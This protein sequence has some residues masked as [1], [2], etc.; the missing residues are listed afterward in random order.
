MVTGGFMSRVRHAVGYRATTS[1]EVRAVLVQLGEGQ[2]E[3]RHLRAEQEAGRRVPDREQ[4]RVR[5]RAYVWHPWTPIGGTDERVM[6]D[7]AIGHRLWDA[8]GTEYVDASA[9]NATCG[10]GHPA[11]VA[12]AAGQTARLHGVDLSV[13]N[14]ELAGLLA[15]RLA[16]ALPAGLSR[17]LFTNSGS[18]AIEASCFIAA[19]S[20]AQRGDS[21]RRMVTFARG[22]HGSTML[23]RSLSGLPPT[24]HPFTSPLD[25]TPV[26][27]SV[28]DRAVRDPGSAPAILDSFAAAIGDDPSDL[29]IAVLIEPLINVGGGVILPP[30]LLRGIRELCDARGVLLILDEVFTGIGR[31]GRMF[32]FEHDDIEPDIVVCS[33]GLS[34]GY[35]PIA[36][37]AVRD[38]LYRAFADD[39]IMGGLRYGHT[40]SGHA[41]ACAVSLATLEVLEKEGLVERSRMLGERLLAGLV[42]LAEEADVV[43]VRGLGL[44]VVLEMSDPRAAAELVAEARRQGLLLRQQ[45]TAVMVVPPLSVD[46]EVVD[47]IA[48]RVRRAV[49]ATRVE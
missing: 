15:E 7:T 37:V 13:H 1:R 18:E 38:E 12:A 16:A 10:Y 2:L 27:I 26:E 21:R 5:D 25:V 8:D 43:D 33:K 46:A 6:A 11:V 19:S 41:V 48:D 44:L 42:S 35:A 3:G 30:G 39:P 49:R 24:A 34:G 17:I 23:A 45:H 36:A 20:L 4:A 32:G 31:T 29:P 28:P 40:T 14:H 47:D 9:L 22:Y